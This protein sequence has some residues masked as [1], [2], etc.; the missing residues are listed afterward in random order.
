MV[1]KS[2]QGLEVVGGL[3]CGLDDAL[4]DYEVC[5]DS[6]VTQ[7]VVDLL[8]DLE[9]ANS[10]DTTVERLRQINDL[11]SDASYVYIGCKFREL[12]IC[13][14]LVEAIQGS[15]EMIVCQEAIIC[16]ALCCD[17]NG[18]AMETLER[19]TPDYGFV[20]VDALDRFGAPIACECASL[21]RC[22][23]KSFDEDA[24]GKILEI[25]DECDYADPAVYIAFA[26]MVWHIIQHVGSNYRKLEP[27]LHYYT[28]MLT[29]EIYDFVLDGLMFMA[30]SNSEKLLVNFVRA[31]MDACLDDP[32]IVDFLVGYVMSWDSHPR[33]RIEMV[34]EILCI[35]L[36]KTLVYAPSCVNALQ[37]EV[38]FNMMRGEIPVIQNSAARLLWILTESTSSETL[39]NLREMD[40]VREMFILLEGLPF[41]CTSQVAFCLSKVI[42]HEDF[43]EP[44]IIEMT[45][46]IL[47]EK[48]AEF[49]D[50]EDDALINKTMWA[51]WRLLRIKDTYFRDT[52]AETLEVVFND[53]DG[54]ARMSDDCR[55]LCLI[56]EK[57]VKGQ[58]PIDS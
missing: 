36:D 2:L 19:E 56:V 55:S 32:L 35:V 10:T 28:V 33:E 14:L 54:W 29:K 1:Y 5:S 25:I 21:F 6:D 23:V 13:D 53:E 26:E 16:L 40:Y 44:E 7:K 49:L 38:L 46:D 17:K 30:K 41:V 45:G 12:H 51:F 9:Q 18:T 48:L 34:L 3:V 15:A 27:V 4:Y 24:L 31:R 47:V 37:P 22:I 11:L 58:S 50:L 8:K 39:P 20:V 52:V 57:H 42:G 43:D